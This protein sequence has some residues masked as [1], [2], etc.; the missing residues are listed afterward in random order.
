M[1]GE[2]LPKAVKKDGAIYIDDI[3]SPYSNVRSL[4]EKIYK[5]GLS[6]DPEA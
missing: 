6:V 2:I 3:E 4:R 5:R 1:R